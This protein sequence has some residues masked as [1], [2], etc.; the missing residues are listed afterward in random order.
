MK[1][2]NATELNRKSGAAQW[3][4]LLYAYPP[5][6]SCPSIG[7][8][9]DREQQVKARRA[10]G[11]TSAQ[12]GRAGYRL[13]DDPDPDFLYV[14]PHKT[15]CAPFREERRMKFASAGKVHRKSGGAP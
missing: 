2:P 11:Q 3:R 6:K 15:A 14:A 8:K 5:R 13:E 7:L 12:P 9:R 10:G 4:D 1:L